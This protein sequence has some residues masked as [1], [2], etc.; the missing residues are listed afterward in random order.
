MAVRFRVEQEI[1]TRIA[2]A[3]MGGRDGEG[4]EVRHMSSEAAFAQVRILGGC[5]GGNVKLGSQ[6]GAVKTLADISRHPLET[7]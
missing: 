1:G 7:L 6:G 5:W 2:C 3:C 4:E